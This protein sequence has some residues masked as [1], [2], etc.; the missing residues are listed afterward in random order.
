MFYRFNLKLFAYN[1]FSIANYNRK[2]I[3]ICFKITSDIC[4]MYEYMI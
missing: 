2:K 1:L 4:V 3:D